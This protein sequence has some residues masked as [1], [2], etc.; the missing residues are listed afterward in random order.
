VHFSGHI[1]LRKPTALVLLTVLA[2]ISGAAVAAQEVSA[3][4]GVPSRPESVH[5]VGGDTLAAVSWS[6]PSVGGAEVAKYVVTAHPSGKTCYL[7]TPVYELRCV[8]VGLKNGTSYTFTVAALNK[9][10]LG[11]TSA[12]SAEVKVEGLPTSSSVSEINDPSFNQPAAI[13]ADASDIWVANLAGGTEGNG[14]VSE[15]DE[16]TNT[17]TQIN[18]PSFNEPVAM[19]END[20]VIWVANIRGGASANGS[21]SEID[22]LSGTVTELNDPS[23]QGPVGVTFDGG[24]AWVLNSGTQ[25]SN[26]NEIGSISKVDLSTGTVTSITSN[27]FQSVDAIT[28]SGNYVWVSDQFGG[29][30]G[31]GSGAVSKIDIATGAVTVISKLNVIHDPNDIA[32]NGSEVWVTNE[33][34]GLAVGGKTAYLPLVAMINATTD[35]VSPAYGPLPGDAR[36]TIWDGAHAWFDPQHEYSSSYVDE[37]NIATGKVLQ[38]DT[39]DLTNAAG[40]AAEGSDIW[41]TDNSGGSTGNG[42]VTKIAAP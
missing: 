16:A 42:F 13:V 33:G 23:F 32:T 39:A 41:V 30:T 6:P 3:A 31:G 4:A 12:A 14:S 19:A 2:L 28:S 20:G 1:R 36:E 15:I 5:V 21:I 26:G 38:L 10:G 8:I 40:I 37:V 7:T 25:D 27:S 17:V 22:A 11:A 35:A 18:D 24:Y 9:G 29:P 34:E